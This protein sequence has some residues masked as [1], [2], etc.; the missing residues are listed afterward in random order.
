M[1]NKTRDFWKHKKAIEFEFDKWAR[2]GVVGHFRKKSLNRRF[3][4]YENYGDDEWT[5][6]IPSSK[7]S[8]SRCYKRNSL[9]N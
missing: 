9:T 1:K 5:I 7:S 8:I 2:T 6:T 4:S 3:E